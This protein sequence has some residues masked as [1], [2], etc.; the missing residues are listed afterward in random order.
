MWPFN[1][2]TSTEDET[3]ATHNWFVSERIHGGNP[4]IVRADAAFRGRGGVAGYTHQVG[5]AVPL[6]K[7]EPNGLPSTEESE[8][9]NLIEETIC[10]ELETGR[11]SMLVGVITTNGMREF[12]LYTKDPKKMQERFARWQELLVS[13]ELQ[14]MIQPDRAWDVYNNLV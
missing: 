4:M 8:Q 3:P 2:K 5:I 12:V 10:G 6:R 13:H 9:L 1:K 7:P 14:L 11:E